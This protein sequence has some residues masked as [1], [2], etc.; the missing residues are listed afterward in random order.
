ML[1]RNNK[2]DL[3]SVIKTVESISVIISI[4]G[5]GIIYT[6]LWN[7]P[8]L[9][10]DT[11]QP[12]DIDTMSVSGVLI[13]NEGHATAHEIT[14]F[15]ESNKLIKNYKIATNEPYTIYRGGS[16]Q[17]EIG[18]KIGKLVGGSSINVYLLTEER[19]NLNPSVMYENG[20][21]EPAISYSTITVLTFWSSVAL[22][23]L[24]ISVIIIILYIRFKNLIENIRE[25]LNSDIIDKSVDFNKDNDY[26]KALGLASS[27]L[28][29]KYL[30]AGEVKNGRTFQYH[31]V[32]NFLVPKGEV[33][34]EIEKSSIYKLAK[35]AKVTNKFVDDLLETLS[36]YDLIKPTAD[37]QK[38]IVTDFGKKTFD[39]V[40]FYLDRGLEMNM[41]KTL[42]DNLLNDIY[43]KSI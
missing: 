13:R 32:K 29:K 31:L 17:K 6:F 23:V 27:N 26:W 40:S 33:N 28:I 5:I 2:K 9:K 14:I 15:I 37:K 3:F 38:I 11:I 22:I 21:A 16:N 30:D 39:F 34:A 4:I 41:V 43:A 25:Y 7:I 10:Y 19:P 20:Y 42:P 8:S 1:F 12:Y 24:V 35:K 18:I 36:N